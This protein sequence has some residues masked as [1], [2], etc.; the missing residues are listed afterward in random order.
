MTTADRYAVAG[1]PVEHS[2]SPLIHAQFAQQTG[3]AVD[4]GRLLCPLDDFKAHIKAFAAGGAKGCNVT[5]PF[6]FEAF[7]LASQRTPRA[8]LAQAANTLRFDADSAGG[9]VADNTDGVGLVR[10]I[11]VNAGV[12]LAGKRVL[13]LGAGGAS[14]GVLGPLIEARPTEIVMANRTVEKAQAIVDR[15][16]AWAAQHGV[17]LSARGL[18]DPGTAFDVFINGTAASLAGSGVPVG[19][20]VLKPGTLALD[21]MYG[22]AAHA[23]L[24]WARSHGAVPRDGLGMLVEQA[25]ESFTLWRGVRPDTAP[26][27]AHMRALVD[28]A[29]PH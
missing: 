6:K 16:A 28:A 4:Y 27:L 12:A 18:Q 7:E 8:E 9:W 19:P 3:Q 23:F 25:A 2:R 20:E 11:T 22:P 13:L 14:A 24:D 1:N 15:H 21:M 10:D 29:Q 5:V 26:V 17:A